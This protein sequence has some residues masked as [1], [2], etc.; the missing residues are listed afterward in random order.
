VKQG[1]WL[2]DKARVGTALVCCTVPFIFPASLKGAT[3]DVQPATIVLDG[4][5]SSKILIVRNPE[6][7]DLSV[8]IRAQA[9][10]QN[11]RGE[12][13]YEDTRDI[14]VYPKTLILGKGQTK[15]V[16]IVP[17][18]RP[19]VGEKAYRVCFE[20]LRF[21]QD[22]G[23]SRSAPSPRKAIPLFVGVGSRKT[24]VLVESASMEKGKLEL[25]VKNDG[26]L[27]SIVTGINVMGLDREG[28]EVFSRDIG[29]W[30]VLAGSSRLYQMPIPLEL[31]RDV[32]IL[33]IGV[34]IDSSPWLT[35]R[36]ALDA[37]SC[38]EAE[39]AYLYGLTRKAEGNDRCDD[40]NS[41][42]VAAFGIEGTVKW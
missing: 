39:G 21:R 13:V 32:K 33:N 6:K 14:S 15:S 7:D 25:R 4:N 30:Y 29:G 28:R 2:L 34:K 16:R 5:S 8:Q 3:I 17:R 22:T 11:E 41:C 27:H 26:S 42:T 1:K 24:R 38:G 12:D 37:T 10:G 9:W 35:K 31:C 23:A 20:G 18:N 19:G 36:I 40:G